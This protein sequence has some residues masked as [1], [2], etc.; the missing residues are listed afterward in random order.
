M[1]FGPWTYDPDAM[2]LYQA[3]GQM[4]K[5]SSRE[6]RLL[7]LFLSHPGRVFSRQQLLD[8]LHPDGDVE[9]YDR[10]IDSA[11]ARLRRRIEIDPAA[12]KILKTVYGEGYVFN[13]NVR[14]LDH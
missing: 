10:A 2:V 13:A 12:P 8:V 11:I 14:R 5:L 6:K 9:V 4:V 7:T 1:R 3:T